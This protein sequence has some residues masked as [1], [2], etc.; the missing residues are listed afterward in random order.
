MRS[1]LD[2]SKHNVPI[3]TIKKMLPVATEVRQ[4]KWNRGDRYYITMDIEMDFL[5]IRLFSDESDER[6]LTRS[7]LRKYN[8]VDL[9]R[10]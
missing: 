3:K 10:N 7:E 5:N 9:A 1:S 2:L 6:I 4:W 8:G